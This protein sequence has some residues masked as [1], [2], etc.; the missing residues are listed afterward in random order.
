[1]DIAKN[2][3]SITDFTKNTLVK[4][5]VPFPVV[6]AERHP[7]IVNKIGRAHV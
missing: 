5:N 3:K 1:M 2:T 4:Y 6:L 7:H